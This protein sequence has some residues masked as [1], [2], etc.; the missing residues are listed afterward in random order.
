MGWRFLFLWL[1][2]CLIKVTRAP[3]L[4]W[5]LTLLCARNHSL[6]LV[7]SGQGVIMAPYV[8]SLRVF[9]CALLVSLNSAHTFTGS[10]SIKLS[11][12]LPI[13]LSSISCADPEWSCPYFFTLIYG[14]T[15]R[16]IF[17]F[18][19]PTL[20]IGILYHI[21]IALTSREWKGAYRSPTETSNVAFLKHTSSGR[22]MLPS[23]DILHVFFLHVKQFIIKMQQRD[24]VIC[25]K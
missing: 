10:T 9:Y 17:T 19:Q 20:H 7:S 21:P 22:L 5:M 11:S 16:I 1:F 3:F 13:E 2:P 15:K 4:S 12:V 14:W 23:L 8:T 6:P 18:V 24:K 25:S